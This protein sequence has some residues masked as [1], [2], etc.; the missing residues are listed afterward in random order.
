MPVVFYDQDA[1]EFLEISDPKL[2]APMNEKIEE[3]AIDIT[4]DN[5]QGKKFRLIRTDYIDEIMCRELTKE[6][7]QLA[8]FDTD[9]LAHVLQ[10]P[11]RAIELLKSQNLHEELGTSIVHFDRVVEVQEAYVREYGYTGYFPYL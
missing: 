9:F 11:K 4:F 1:C 7:S 3:G 6:P 10:W 8:Y 2:L 5:G